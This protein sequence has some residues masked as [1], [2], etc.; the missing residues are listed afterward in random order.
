MY[1][2]MYECSRHLSAGLFLTTTYT[3]QCLK[4]MDWVL[5]HDHEHWGMSIKSTHL[6]L[7]YSQTLKLCRLHDEASVARR[8]HSLGWRVASLGPCRFGFEA[9]FMNEEEDHVKR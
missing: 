4:W 8:F 2:C 3:S 5:M 6:V 1:V 9:Q 7:D